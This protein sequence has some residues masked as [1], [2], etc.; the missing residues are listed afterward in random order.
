MA[1]FTYIDEYCIISPSLI[2]VLMVNSC[3]GFRRLLQIQFIQPRFVI[4]RP[5]VFLA[6]NSYS[7]FFFGQHKSF[8][9]LV[10]SYTLAIRLRHFVLLDKYGRYDLCAS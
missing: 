3:I 4:K 10:L 5:E 7:G 9:R 6:I 2:A 8:M 1:V